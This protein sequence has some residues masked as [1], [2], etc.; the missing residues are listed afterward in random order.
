LCSSVKGNQFC[1]E[2]AA[3]II[4]VELH[5]EDGGSTFHSSVG[6]TCLTLSVS[7]CR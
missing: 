3:C 4:R 5:S 1:G 7:D 6:T 2:T